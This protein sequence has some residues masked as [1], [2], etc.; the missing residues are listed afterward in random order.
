MSFNP[1]TDAAFAAIKA[2]IAKLNAEQ[3]EEFID[4]LLEY[5]ANLHTTSAALNPAA[6][7]N[8]VNAVTSSVR[9][10]KRQF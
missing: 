2:Q 1:E 5:V 9:T 3:Y 6:M 10:H 8:T 4:R 7:T